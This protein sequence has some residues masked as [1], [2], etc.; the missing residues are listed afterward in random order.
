M[1]S[2]RCGRLASERWRPRSIS[3]PPWPGPARRRVWWWPG[4]WARRPECAG[5]F[6]ALAETAKARGQHLIVVSGAGSPDPELTAASTVSPAVVHEATAYLQAGG[7]ENVAQL[8]RFLADHLLLTGFGREPPAEQPQHGVYHPDLPA[9]AHRGRLAG[10]PRP[11]PP[12]G[13]RPLLS[14][15]LDERQS[16]PHRRLLVRAGRRPAGAN[17]LPYLPHRSRM[18]RRRRRKVGRPPCRSS[19]PTV[20]RSSTF[21]GDD[22][23]LRPRRRECRRPD[24]GR[25]VDGRGVFAALGVPVLQAICGGTARWQWEA[26]CAAASPRSTRR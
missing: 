5:L 8:L 19:S 3:P 6:A 25:L 2:R 26:S 16:R 17:A 1:A 20:S 22:G 13:R 18:N 10:P 23:F 15:P 4:S 11:R 12:D 9:A 21:A 7:P 24:A 14:R